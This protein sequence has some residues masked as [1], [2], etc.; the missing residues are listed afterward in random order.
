MEFFLIKQGVAQSC[1]LSPTYTLFLIYING[2]LCE[3]EKCLELGV[4]FSENTLSGLLLANDFVGL[5][6]TGSALP[7]LI[8]IVCYYSKCWRFEANVKKV[9]CYN[10][11]KSSQVQVGGFGV[12]KA[13]QFWILTVI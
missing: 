5:V 2:L 10:F 9:C 3:V 1:T 4:K 8:D 12:V 13:F 7:K 6:Q 11:F